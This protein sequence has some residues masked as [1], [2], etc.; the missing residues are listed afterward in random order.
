MFALAVAVAVSVALALAR[1]LDLK[2]ITFFFA[3]PSKGRAAQ[4]LQQAPFN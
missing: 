1:R 2:L 3:Y 4:T